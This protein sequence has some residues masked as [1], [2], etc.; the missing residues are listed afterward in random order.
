MDKNKKAM[1]G[2]DS[3]ESA[4]DKIKLSAAPNSPTLPVAPQSTNTGPSV[5]SSPKLLNTKNPSILSSEKLLNPT[6]PPV[7]KP[8]VFVPQAAM[9]QAETIEKLK[10]DK[11][12]PKGVDLIKALVPKAPTA[13]MIQADTTKFN[14]K[15]STAD[16]IKNNEAMLDEMDKKIK[17]MTGK[18]LQKDTLKML[19]PAF[20]NIAATVNQSNKDKGSKDYDSEHITVQNSQSLFTMTANQISGTPSYRMK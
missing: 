13:P 11:N 1:L 6:V 16:N 12:R 2:T 14:S 19:Q 3:K 7:F 5:L 15:T 9:P 10:T 4:M 18:K 17:E 20:T 8:A